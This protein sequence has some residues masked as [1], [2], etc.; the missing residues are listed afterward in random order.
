MFDPPI[1]LHTASGMFSTVAA[2]PT[3]AQPAGFMLTPPSPGQSGI[4]GMPTPTSRPEDQGPHIVTI[5][6][7]VMSMDPTGGLVLQPGTTL[8]NGDVPVT[9]DGTA[10][11][12]GPSEVVIG[13]GQEASTIPIINPSPGMAQII[14]VG[15]KT[16]SLDPSGAMAINPGSSLKIGDAPAVLDGTTISIGSSG[17]LVAD[18]K[19][20]STIPIPMPSNAP[21]P[22]PPANQH[23]VTIG[24]NTYT[25]TNGQLTLAPGLTLS[26]SGAAAVISGT[27]VSLESD[28]IV[29]ASASSTSKISITTTA[30]AQT[31]VSPS[32]S[33]RSTGKP[34][35]TSLR[36]S[37]ADDVKR[38]WHWAAACVLLWF[39]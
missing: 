8:K 35:A 30:T 13:T 21:P 20:T 1:A 7:S 26:V 37:G 36:H 10:I 38:G 15:Q 3:P 11:S 17:I 23:I 31:G 39:I 16:L 4:D 12:I 34:T 28:A 9:M 24:S 19:G 5:G 29:I 2:Q 14:V 18:A 22:P 25:E 33:V 6:S 27:T 32:S